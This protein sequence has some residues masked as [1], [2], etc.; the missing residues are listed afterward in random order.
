MGVLRDVRYASRRLLRTPVFS[1]VAL[2]TLAVTIGINSAIFGVLEAIDLRRLPV[3][4][5][6][7]LVLVSTTTPDGP[8]TVIPFR[9]F[10]Q[11]R[12]QSRTFSQVIGSAGD[13]VLFLEVNGATT[14]G[15]VTFVTGDYYATLGARADAGRLIGEADQDP[16]GTR[17]A[18][19][20]VVSAEFWQRRL[21]GDPLVLGRTI[22][23]QGV[24]FTIVGIAPRGFG[25]TSL[26]SV[27]DI[28]LPVGAVASVMSE[29]GVTF[30]GASVHPWIQAVG[31]LRSGITIDAAR[32]SLA[33]VWPAMRAAALPPA[34]TGT[35]RD[36]FLSYPLVVTSAMRGADRID[37]ADFTDA[38]HLAM[39]IS[40]LI[41]LIACVNLANL[42]L[43]RV[44]T[45]GRELAIRAS[46]GASRWASVREA[47]L[48]SVLLS[49]AGA[50]G[51]LLLAWW[52]IRIF[53]AFLADLLSSGTMP[54]TAQLDAG[55]VIFTAAAGLLVGALASFSALGWLTRS[56]SI[57]LRAHP[58]QSP[59]R[60]GR[61]GPGLVT[62]QIA[63]SMVMVSL[64]GLAARNIQELRTTQDLGYRRDG[65]SV[66]DLQPQ[67]HGYEDVDNDSYQ[68][69]LIARVT[70][71]PGIRGASLT[72]AATG[73]YTQ[74]PVSTRDGA[75]VG[76]APWTAVS[77]GFFSM[78]GVPLLEG[79]DF[80]WADGQHASRVAIV[81]RSLATRLFGDRSPIGQHVRIGPAADDQDIAIVGVVSDARLNDPRTPTFLAV[82]VPLLQSGEQASWKGLLVRGDARAAFSEHDLSQVIWDLGHDYVYS[83]GALA[84][85]LDQNLLYERGIAKVA[86]FA[87]AVA[88]TLVAIGL[89]GLWSY[90]V[91]ERRKEMA[92][93]L[94]IGARPGQIV[95]LVLASGL[96]VA[97]IGILVGTAGAIGTGHL[98]QSLLVLVTPHDPMTMLLA[99]SVV[100]TVSVA[101]CLLPAIRAA[102]VDPISALR[103][104]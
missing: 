29:R 63:M 89:Y 10:Q 79:R 82:Y 38:L 52:A 100:L 50:G 44:A 76:T 58:A 17:F 69:A 73:S 3:D 39:G 83:V 31:R 21:G 48:E 46:L 18:P 33:A 93:R 87:A 81:S 101:A 19:V 26:T 24:P 97:G 4:H 74:Q 36:E 64:A 53:N 55:V 103:A 20:A 67:P 41:L 70:T 22:R 61:F 71:L 96:R 43:S 34:Y 92:I 65:V 16:G 59:R 45:R 80:S 104:E 1:S 91:A 40:T 35:Q 102:S 28:A 90:L 68:A 54:F 62:V 5:P 23:V 37:Y 27:P 47:L 14:R 95:T 12:Q 88:L 49:L 57:S 66:V 30:F 42:L 60:L 85:E 75:R 56:A 6:E 86:G 94:A 13:A 25:G 9:L 77:P 99:P 98:V 84:Q 8:G 2:L 32:A 11:V 78:L 72:S 7:E 15:V 51:G